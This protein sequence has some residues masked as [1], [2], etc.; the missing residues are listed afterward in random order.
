MRLLAVFDR[1]S[2]RRL[3]GFEKKSG[4]ASPEARLLDLFAGRPGS[5]GV[6]VTPRRAVECAAVHC[7]VQ[8]ISE[9]MGQLP[10]HV[11]KRGDDGTK[12]RDADHPAAMLLD[13]ASNDWTPASKFREDITRTSCISPR[14]P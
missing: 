12:Q 11:L 3:F 7:A 8:A 13:I 4:T 1:F 6:L 9:S 5:A 14:R 10:V 2:I